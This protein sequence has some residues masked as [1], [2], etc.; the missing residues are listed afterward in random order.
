MLLKSDRN[1]ANIFCY[2]GKAGKKKIVLLTAMPELPS[3]E[4]KTDC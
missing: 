1:S 4:L 2:P 3:I